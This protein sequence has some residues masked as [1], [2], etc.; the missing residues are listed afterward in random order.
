MQLRSV[1]LDIILSMSSITGA[2]AGTPSWPAQ[3][4]RQLLDGTL[5]LTHSQLQATVQNLSASLHSPAQLCWL[6]HCCR[7]SVLCR[8]DAQSSP[9]AV[10]ESQQGH[11]TQLLLRHA[12]Q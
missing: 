10:H 5:L 12:Q 7:R 11:D 1:L 6:T 2:V 4:G 3:T 9:G 8:H